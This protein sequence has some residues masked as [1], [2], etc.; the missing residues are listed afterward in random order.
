M[1][2]SSVVENL[3]PL[4]SELK[5][6]PIRTSTAAELLSPDP[7]K[8]L[9]V[10]LAQNPPTIPPRFVIAAA[11]PLMIASVVPKSCSWTSRSEISAWIAG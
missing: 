4:K 6:V 8:T 3:S 9:D 5:I 2:A 1:M 7:L 10:T 11:T